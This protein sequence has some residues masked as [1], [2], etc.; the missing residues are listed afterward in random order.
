MR[1][2]FSS[3]DALF[4]FGERMEVVA[5]N[6]AAEELTGISSEEAIGRPCWEVLAGT[7]ESGDAYCH[8][9]CST[10][11]LASEGWPVRPRRMVIKCP[12]GPLHVNVSTIA[13]R[14]GPTTFVHLLTKAPSPEPPAVRRSTELTPRRLEVLRLLAEGLSAKQIATRLGVTEATARN[15]I[16]AIRSQLGCHSQLQAVAEARRR[17]LTP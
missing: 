5:W 11:R 12:L 2:D 3:G 8:A 17:G 1:A 14:N 10:F 15:H 16:R 7:D 6:E 13:L 9:G 4:A